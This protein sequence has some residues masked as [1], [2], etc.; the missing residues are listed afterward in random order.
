MIIKAERCTGCGLC[1]LYCPVGAIASA[2]ARTARGKPLREVSLAACVEC[3]N[4]L[5]AAGCPGDALVAQP[6]EWPRTVRS[7][8]SNP[9]TVHKDSGNLGRGTEEMK[10]N[11]V[12]GRI[13]RGEAGITVEL[14]RPAT[15]AGLKDVDR[16]TRALAPL[17]AR[18]ESPLAGLVADPVTGALREDVLGERVLSMIVEW[19][20]PEER[21]PEVLGV[22]R[23]I[24]P[25]LE[26][27]FSLGVISAL[28]EAGP[29]TVPEWI[30]AAGFEPRPN[31]KMNLGLGRPI[32]E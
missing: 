24:A 1:E 5:R 10:T 21:L 7:T 32:Q 16:V 3:G 27:V 25:T 14:G 31:G 4:C 17:G 26:T 22:L 30:R 19:K 6:L 18:F 8:F 15:G 9:Q 29:D 23:R 11:E 20:V 12:T 13:R 2:E 28:P